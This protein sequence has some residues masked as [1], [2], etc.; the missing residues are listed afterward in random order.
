M[1]H[2][3]CLFFFFFLDEW[4]KLHSQSQNFKRII[5][6]KWLLFWVLLWVLGRAKTPEVSVMIWGKFVSVSWKKLDLP[7]KT[8]FIMSLEAARHFFFCAVGTDM[9]IFMLKYFWCWWVSVLTVSCNVNLCQI[10][11]VILSRSRDVWN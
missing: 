3:L 8:E 7:D 10:L 5:Q 4:T 11:A 9:V 6:V 1:Y 2:F